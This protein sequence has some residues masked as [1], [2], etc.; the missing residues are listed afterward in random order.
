MDRTEARLIRDGSV[1]EGCG[2]ASSGRGRRWDGDAV[3]VRRGEDLAP[4]TTSMLGGWVRAATTD[5]HTA[6]RP[7]VRVLV[8]PGEGVTAETGLYAGRDLGAKRAPHERRA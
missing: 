3:G 4:V 2:C 8:R 7:T 1:L 5:A 6:T